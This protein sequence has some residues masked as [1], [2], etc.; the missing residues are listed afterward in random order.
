M[1][2]YTYNCNDDKVTCQ[3]ISITLTKGYYKLELWGAQGG[4]VSDLMG[5]YGGYS[6][7][8]I[9]VKDPIKLYLFIGASGFEGESGL[10]ENAFNGGG[11]GTFYTKDY[12]SASGG[13]ATDIRTGLD[14]NTRIIIAGGGGGASYHISGSKSRG[15]SGGGLHGEDGLDGIYSGSRYN[16]GKGGKNDEGGSSTQQKGVLGYGGNQT[17]SASIGS[18]GGGG[19]YG[20]GS[21]QAYGASGGGGSGY[22]SPLLLMPLMI[23]GNSSMPSFYTGL[24]SS[25]GH[26]GDGA[27]K[28]TKVSFATCN[29][30]N[31]NMFTLA[32]L[33]FLCWK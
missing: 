6:R 22:I 17:G 23:N 29:I 2:R 16:S 18:G 27:I 28:I 13:G 12:S 31:K 4:N 3:P 9:A 14:L 30:R 20:G 10:T 33:I 24:I 11:K 5:G 19:Y 25:K 26:I 7:G 32:S 8:V 15:G 21:G 1:A